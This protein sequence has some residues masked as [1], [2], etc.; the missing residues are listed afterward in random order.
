MIRVRIKI[1]N[2]DKIFTKN[3]YLEDGF[4]VCKSNP[5]LIAIVEKACE[6]SH[7]ED[8]EEVKVTSYF[9]W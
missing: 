2:E 3:E 7:I 9:E 1:K 5:K 8:I 4:S 6:E